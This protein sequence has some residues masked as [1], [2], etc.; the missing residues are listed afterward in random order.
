MSLSSHPPLPRDLCGIKAAHHA[1]KLS[2]ADHKSI[3]G[4]LHGYCAQSMHSVYDTDLRQYRY[5]RCISMGVCSAIVL[6]TDPVPAWG[7]TLLPVH[8]TQL[9]VAYPHLKEQIKEQAT[10]SECCEF[11]STLEQQLEAVLPNDMQ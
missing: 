1:H 10:G 3:D 2:R 9:L 7:Q 4:S 8:C 5:I 6:Q 11:N